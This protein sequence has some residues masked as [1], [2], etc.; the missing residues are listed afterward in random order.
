MKNKKRVYAYY[1]GSNFYHL[2]KLNYKITSIFFH[3]VTNQLMDLENERLIKIKYFNSPVSQ[4]E[5]P[6][7]YKRQ[8]KFF[9]KLKKTPF[10]ELSLGRLVKRPLNKINIKCQNC[11]LQKADTINCPKC[12][13]QIKITETYK[14][15]EKGIDVQLTIS[16]L[17][18]ALNNKYDTALLFSGDADFVP[19][20]K[21]IIKNLK[22]EVI[23]CYFPKPKTNELIQSCSDKRLIT[24]EIIKNSQINS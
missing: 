11:G 9:E 20:I 17:L 14:I 19:A 10:L 24:K 18:D 5:E 8:L 22:K 6:E 15:T 12:K 21:Y 7:N 2:L 13:N 16:L 3:H 4:Q 23:F 1:D